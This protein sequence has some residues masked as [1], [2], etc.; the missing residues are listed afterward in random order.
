M[1]V[2]YARKLGISLRLRPRLLPF[3]GLF[4]V[5]NER[6]KNQHYVVGDHITRVIQARA[7]THGVGD[8]VDSGCGLGRGLAAGPLA[9]ECA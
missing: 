2:K 5:Q 3:R 9:G 6:E 7:H 4:D 1:C 8:W